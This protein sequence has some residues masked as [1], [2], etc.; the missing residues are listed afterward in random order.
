MKN[1]ELITLLVAFIGSVVGTYI[2]IPR[3]IGVANERHLVDNPNNRS[4]HK[5]AIPRLGGVAF[6]LCFIFAIILFRDYG[7]S[8]NHFSMLAG[9][10]VMSVVGLRDDI[11]SISPKTKLIGQLVACSFIFLNQNFLLK[12]LHGFL[13]IYELHPALSITLIALF[14]LTVINAFNLIDGIDGLA[15]VIAIVVLS[16]FAIL[17]FSMR[18]FFYLGLCVAGV[19]TLIAFLKYNLAK[20]KTDNCQNGKCKKKIFMGDTGSMILGFVIATMTVRIVTVDAV[21]LSL[22]PFYPENLPLV[23]GAVLFIPLFDLLRVFT[24]RLLKKKEPFSP[25]RRHL[26][27]IVIDNLKISHRRAS[28]FIGIVNVGMIVVFYWFGATFKHYVL[29]LGLLV[30]I[31]I[32]LLFIYYIDY[33]TEHLRN[34]AK[35]K[36]KIKKLRKATHLFNF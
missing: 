32:A 7:N 36:S 19:G 27:H 34:R 12:S 15:A 35:I 2:F 30:L 16:T 33:S 26:H 8:S 6:S 18:K 24:L 5:T 13:G 1:T 23:L 22:L 10:I 9:L 20:I 21:T 28:F 17:F 3:I 29:L 11:K 31:V 14:M 4:S 25:D